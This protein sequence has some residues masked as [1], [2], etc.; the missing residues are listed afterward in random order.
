MTNA[1]LLALQAGKPPLSQE[2]LELLTV[3]NCWLE[4]MKEYCLKQVIARGGCKVK[5]IHG[6]HATGKT[7]YLQALKLY[8]NR[9]GFFTCYFDLQQMEFRITDII[10]LYK[11]IAENLDFAKVRH[12]LLN[13]MLKHL[14]YDPQ[15]LEEH[16][17]TLIDLICEIEDTASFHA[18]QSI[19]KSI[20][21]IVKGIDLSFSFRL[22]LMRYMEA[23]SEENNDLLSILERWVLGAKLEA[24]E[25]R[26]CQLFERLNKQNA[27]I[28]LF[29]L[30]EVIKIS[31]YQGVVLIFDQ[32]EA[33][34]PSPDAPVK[35][36]PAKRND[37]Y[38]MLRQ[39]IDDLDFLKN[40]L[41]LIAG[42]DEIISNEAYGLQSYYALWMRIRQ[43]YVQKRTL[44]PYSDL[45]DADMI[46]Q[47]LASS[48]AL[49]D[50]AERIKANG[51]QWEAEPLSSKDDNP[52]RFHDF[53]SVLR[54]TNKSLSPELRNDR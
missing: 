8:A 31:G 52:I 24:H 23:L 42:T 34:F 12:A 25:K 48:G 1:D 20:N 11:A 4:N 44:N 17:T 36:T 47:D 14:G 49:D 5:I 19:R 9:E 30:I 3:D 22:F 45:V 40:F 53:V 41:L 10:Q 21:Q 35:Y 46:M 6:A 39:L 13:T 37:V 43:D 28:W 26:Q 29:S 16:K 2:I 7:H 32:F 50:L 15:Q 27:R 33:I 18:K 54:R 51:I 38:E